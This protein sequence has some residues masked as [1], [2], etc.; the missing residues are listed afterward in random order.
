MPSNF[1]KNRHISAQY[2]LYFYRLYFQVQNPASWN[3]GRAQK[4]RFQENRRT[5]AHLPTPVGAEYIKIKPK[6]IFGIRRLTAHNRRNTRPNPM[7]SPIRLKTQGLPAEPR[8]ISSLFITFIALTNTLQ[9]CYNLASD[10]L[11]YPRWLRI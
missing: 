6:P 10:P 11:Q 1:D 8:Q 3:D 5:I 4:I 2:R 7:N 9:S